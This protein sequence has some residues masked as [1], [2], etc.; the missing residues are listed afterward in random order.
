MKR[1]VIDGRWIRQTGIG[2]SVEETLRHLLEVDHDNH[3]I[4]LVRDEDRDHIDLKAPNLEL[5]S[6]N[7]TW[8]TMREQTRLLAQIKSLKPDLVH[9]TN[10]NLPVLYRGRFVVTIH[11]LTL[12]RFKN[13][14][15]AKYSRLVYHARDS[16]MRSVMRRAAKGSRAIIVP[17]QFVAAEV[18]KKYHLPKSKLSVVHWAAREPYQRTIEPSEKFGINRPYLLYVGNAYPHKNLERLILAFGKLITEYMLDY[19]LVIAGKKDVFHAA[20][21]R[22]VREAKLDKRVI[23]TDF[24]SDRE[25]AGLYKNAAIYVFPSLSEGFGLPPLEAM[26]YGLPVASSNATCLPEII[27]DAAEF[28][29]PTSID[30]MARVMS[31]LLAD[32]Y[33]RDQLR[34]LGRERVGQFDWSKA[35]QATLEVYQKALRGK[36]N[37]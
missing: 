31:A 22:E 15:T 7:I 6:C 19:Q 2:R 13:I 25:L 17:S 35:A 4:L 21:E 34:D 29:D 28:F 1:I 10:F 30:D 37:A 9:F 3:Y 18:I 27:G 24:V 12:L 33:R 11:D 14:N 36:N 20:L 23:F 16:I 8:Y 5:V 26:S 32:S